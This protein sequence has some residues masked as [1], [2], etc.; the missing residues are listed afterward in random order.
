MGN[1]EVRSYLP[2][3]IDKLIQLDRASDKFC[4]LEGKW[5]Q[6]ERRPFFIVRPDY[7]GGGTVVARVDAH[8]LFGM[9]K[10]RRALVF[11]LSEMG[12]KDEALDLYFKRRKK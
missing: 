7:H 5:K 4:I 3:E 9:W 6:N 8:F 10:V 12:L 1:P 2:V 11:E